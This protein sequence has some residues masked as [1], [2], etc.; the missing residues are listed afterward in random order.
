MLSCDSVATAHSKVLGTPHNCAQRLKPISVTA[1]I[2]F[3]CSDTVQIP[4]RTVQ[5]LQ[6]VE[7]EP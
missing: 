5:M 4:Q 2:T 7:Q 3:V 1:I 6:Q